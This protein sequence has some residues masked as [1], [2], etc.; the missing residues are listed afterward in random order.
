LRRFASPDPG[1]DGWNLY[2]YTLNNP[3]KYLDPDGLAVVFAGAREP[4]YERNAAIREAF[5]RDLEG[6]LPFIGGKVG[7]AVDALV[8]SSLFPASP[9]EFAAN[10]DPAS[11]LMPLSSGPGIRG[12][13]GPGARGTEKGSQTAI[14]KVKDL[15]GLGPG[16]NTLLKHLPDQG[17]PRANWAQNSG[18]LRR[19]MSKGRPIRDASVDPTTGNLIEYPGSFLNAERNLLR[20]HGWT[21]E[22]GTGLWSPP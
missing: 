6:R 8:L 3:I 18:V 2:S 7:D 19:E 14:G 22:P 12:L 17:S 9:A 20:E 5:K 11:F 4:D 16:E 10:A 13:L 21:F 15:Q 1:R